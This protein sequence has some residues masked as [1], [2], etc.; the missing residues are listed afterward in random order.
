[1]KACPMQ[2]MCLPTGED[3]KPSKCIACGICAKAC[4]MG[5]LAV[6]EK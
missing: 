6:E 5:I 4:P 3:A 2:V 1:M